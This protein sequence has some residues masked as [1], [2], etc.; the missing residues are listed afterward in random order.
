MKNNNLTIGVVGGAG[1]VGLPLS[2]LLAK[3]GFKVH[4]I[5][6]NTDAIGKLKQGDIPFLEEGAE[7]LLKEELQKDN[8]GFSADYEIIPECDVLILTVGTPVD[9]HLNPDL[10]SV[11]SVMRMIKPYLLD[12]QVL[13]LRSTLFPGTSDKILKFFKSAGLNIGVSFCPERIAQG[14]AL[15]E[16]ATFPQIISGSDDKSLEMARRVFSPLAPK[17]IELKMK[18][19]ELA[20]LYTNTWRYIKFAVANQ[21]YMMAEEKGMDFYKI[22]EAMSEDYSRA[23][24]FPQ[25]GFAAGPCLFKDTMQL[26]AFN[27]HS[28]PLGHAAMLVNETLPDFIVEQ[29]KHKTSLDGKNVGILGMAFKPNNDD[30]RESLAY[31]LRRILSYENANVMCTD[32]YIEDDQFVTV[33]EI[34]EK[35]GIIFI[36]CAHKEYSQIDFKD[37]MVISP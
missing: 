26:A 28:F 32:I 10:N 3:T 4:I 36:G 21:F 2:L 13:L 34:L 29:T 18:E 27:R 15:K 7:E 14:Y 16:I 37:K 5:D 24:D 30:K 20:K 9:E 17:L 19:A 6:I 12:G 25:V 33:D 22:R 11:F 35:C 31:K 8:L 23:I 1:H